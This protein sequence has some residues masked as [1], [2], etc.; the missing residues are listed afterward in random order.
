MKELYANAEPI[1]ITVG[2]IVCTAVVVVGLWFGIV[3]A[4]HVVGEFVFG[5]TDGQVVP[6]PSRQGPGDD[7]PPPRRV[8][9]VPRTDT[10]VL[11]ERVTRERVHVPSPSAGPS[12]WDEL[13]LCESDGNWSANTGNGFYGGLQFNQ[14]TWVAHGGLKFA[15]RADLATRGQQITVAERLT[16]DGW[17]NCA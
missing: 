4:T 12:Y 11:A 6:F 13:A 10:Q 2:A 17:P 7:T 14:E 5:H 1:F 15:P 8:R 3:G 9:P 16:Y